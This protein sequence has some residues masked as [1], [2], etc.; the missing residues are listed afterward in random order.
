MRYFATNGYRAAI[1]N[2]IHLVKQSFSSGN[3]KCNL[4]KVKDGRVVGSGWSINRVIPADFS[5]QVQ[6]QLEM[7]DEFLQSGK[8]LPYCGVKE[9]GLFLRNDNGCVMFKELSGSLPQERITFQSG[10]FKAI[11]SELKRLGVSI[12]EI[13]GNSKDKLARLSAL[14]DDRV[15]HYLMPC[16]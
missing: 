1:S 13:A 16:V 9:N 12:V 5:W 6:I 14:G 7:L 15:Y 8:D 10:Y 11:V 3:E 2:D 4:Y